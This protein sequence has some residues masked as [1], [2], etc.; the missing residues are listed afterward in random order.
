LKNSLD[1][2]SGLNALSRAFLL[3]QPQIFLLG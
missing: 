2:N 3:Q 1:Q